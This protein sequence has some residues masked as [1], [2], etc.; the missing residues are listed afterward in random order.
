MYQDNSFF[1]K[2]RLKLGEKFIPTG[3]IVPVI[4]RGEVR[5]LLGAGYHRCS[6][7]YYT[8]C[9]PISIGTRVA[10]LKATIRTADRF[11]VDVEIS[12]LYRF[13][14]TE[15]H[16]ASI[17][18]VLCQLDR[19][20]NDWINAV[21]NAQAQKALSKVC[22]QYKESDLADGRLFPRL[23]IK[24]KEA[25]DATLPPF[26]KVAAQKDP[27]TITAIHPPPHIEA[28]RIAARRDNIYA[29]QLSAQ[30]DHIANQIHERNLAENDAEV[31]IIRKS[32]TSSLQ[33][34]SMPNH[35]LNGHQHTNGRQ[36]VTGD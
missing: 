27:V 30:P 25:F 3:H 12:L 9:D 8:Y 23:E 34:K 11:S 17:N 10:K 31:K 4:A 16:L 1:H 26:L 2:L 32:E 36:T 13:E 7:L 24:I 20:Q 14:P 28:A 33:N 6:S 19:H 15:D 29:S 5:Y 18:H 21:L 22:N 35:Y